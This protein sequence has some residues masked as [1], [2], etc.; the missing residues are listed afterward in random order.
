MGTEIQELRK[1]LG[2]DHVEVTK[3][4]AELENL[5]Q[6]RPLHTRVLEGQ[7]R[8]EK[9]TKKV[10]MRRK[11]LAEAEELLRMAH[12][13]RENAFRECEAAQME[14]LHAR[15]RQEELVGEFRGADS[16]PGHAGP[17][18]LGVRNALDLLCQMAPGDEAGMGSK[19]LVDVAKNELAALEYSVKR[20]RGDVG[21]VQ[22]ALGV[23]S[24]PGIDDSEVGTNDLVGC[25]RGGES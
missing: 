15:E 17:C 25:G 21:A 23:A 6:Q 12:E 22:G 20:S 18:L 10:E 2:P 1:M 4:C 16:Q 11:E 8:T 3:R 9:A 7:R 5:R 13:K 14:V 24:G 19:Q